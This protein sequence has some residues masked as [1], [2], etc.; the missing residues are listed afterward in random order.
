M[1]GR[2]R[3]WT[4]LAITNKTTKSKEVVNFKKLEALSGISTRRICSR[5]SNSFVAKH[6]QFDISDVISKLRMLSDEKLRFART[7]SSSG[8]QP[9]VEV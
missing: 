2:V 9:L 1:K 3:S 4:D 6:A 7:N 5:E 8:N